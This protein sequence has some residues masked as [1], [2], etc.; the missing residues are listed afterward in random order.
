MMARDPAGALL[1]LEAEGGEDDVS[2]GRHPDPR[3][4]PRHNILAAH[5]QDR[6]LDIQR[7]P[8]WWGGAARS[9]ILSPT[10]LE[11][12][13]AMKR[14]FGWS[15][16]Y[17]AGEAPGPLRKLQTPFGNPASCRIRNIGQAMAGESLAGLSTMA[18]RPPMAALLIPTVIASGKFTRRDSRRDAQGDVVQRIKFAG[19]LV[20]LR[21]LELEHLPGVVFQVVDGF[22]GVRI[23]FDPVLAHS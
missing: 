18:L 20:D 13:K 12:V 23:G 14:V 6:A 10:S 7:C 19:R 15:H 3:S 8:G 17:L 2:G 9:L 4:R 5:L 22:D 21:Q 11:P 1:P 16:Q